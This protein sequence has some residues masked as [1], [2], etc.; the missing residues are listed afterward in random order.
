[1]ADIRANTPS[2]AAA[3]PSHPDHP[4]WL[5]ERTLAMEIAAVQREGGTLRD[6]ENANAVS[7]QRLEAKKRGPKL[8]ATPSAIEK[9]ASKQ[10]RKERR[11]KLGV[12]Y[13]P[14][15]TVRPAIVKACRTCGV[16]LHCR[17]EIRMLAIMQKA[18]QGDLRMEWLV[19]NL[20]ALQLAM[21]KRI[22]A[23]ITPTRGAPGKEVAF[24]RMRLNAERNL[25]FLSAV[26]E[27]CDWSI[28]SLGAWR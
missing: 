25:A 23:K 21:Q 13:K 15:A 4:R 9:A 5:K 14:V 3:A 24:S 26:T 17:R 19:H 7:L 1:V 22:D 27:I 16:C 11:D 8:V 20:V 2:A 18:G 10:R 28:R 6:A 12:T